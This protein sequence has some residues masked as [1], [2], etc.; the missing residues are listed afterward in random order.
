MAKGS[1]KLHTLCDLL[2]D[3][4]RKALESGRYGPPYTSRR[5][6]T[7]DKS[8]AFRCVSYLTLVRQIN[9]LESVV[10]DLERQRDEELHG[11]GKDPRAGK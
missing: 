2:G 7:R 1:M 10:V 9:A 5:Y 8:V 11:S 3:L 4:K 6:D